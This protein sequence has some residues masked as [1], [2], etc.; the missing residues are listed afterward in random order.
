M[1]CSNRKPEK[2]EPILSTAVISS[3][4]SATA[5]QSNVDVMQHKANLLRMNHDPPAAKILEEK[6]K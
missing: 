5:S 1:G 4:Q 6:R 3:A 2:N